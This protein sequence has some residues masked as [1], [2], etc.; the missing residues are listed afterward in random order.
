MAER[1]GFK[2][3][4]EREAT[5]REFVLWQIR[6]GRARLRQ[7]VANFA[8]YYQLPTPVDA[9]EAQIMDAINF[10]VPL[11]EDRERAD[12]DLPGFSPDFAATLLDET[13]EGLA[14]LPLGK[15]VSK[16]RR[17]LRRWANFVWDRRRNP[18]GQEAL[19]EPAAVLILAHVVGR[20]AG[21]RFGYSRSHWQS[22]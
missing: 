5:P 18:R 15:S 14:H 12:S 3:L 1:P 16:P 4:S 9:L 19:I 22:K 21:R 17:T 2:V 13:V 11:T 20:L 7:A 6:K 8:A 10:I